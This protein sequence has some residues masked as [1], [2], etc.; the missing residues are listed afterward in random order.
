GEQVARGGIGRVW[1]AR[2]TRLD[3]SVAIKELLL[4][5]EAQER[6][7]VR[8]ALL[9]ARLQHP[10]IVPVYEAGRG[11][12]GGALYAMKPLPGRTLLDLI[13]E[14]PTLAGRLALLS[15]V[16]TVAQAVAYAHG[17]HVIHRDLK[18]SNVLVGDFGETM[19]IDW[20]VAKQMS[21]HEIVPPDSHVTV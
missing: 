10:A 20:G 17:Q 6:R 14:S 9:T 18:P 3:R 21:E 5:D 16:L 8:E 15:H 19:I 2:D 11:P 1:C 7:F 12:P 13:A 4:R